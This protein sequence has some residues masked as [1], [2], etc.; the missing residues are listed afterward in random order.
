MQQNI[1]NHSLI[2]CMLLHVISM[3][4]VYIFSN[5]LYVTGI[6]FVYIYIFVD[7]LYVISIYFVYIYHTYI[8]IFY[9]VNIFY[10]YIF[11]FKCL[12]ILYI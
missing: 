12:Y 6:Y 3:Y 2:C 11:S 5:I 8:Y 4:I 1:V 7:I 9:V 10:Y